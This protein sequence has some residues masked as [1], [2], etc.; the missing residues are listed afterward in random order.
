MMIPFV[1]GAYTARSPNLN[2][3]RSVCWFPVIDQED[4]K[5]IIAMYGTPGCKRFALVEAESTDTIIRAV[6]PFGAV[7]YVV[8]GDRV[9]SV[10][11][12]GTPTL[13]GTITTASGNVF[14]AD[15]GTE[16]LIVD[17]TFNGYYISGGVLTAIPDADFPTAT[18]CTFQDGY[19]IV[20]V[21]STGQIWISGLYDVTTWD[22]LDFST[23]EGSPDNALNVSSNAHDLWIFGAL[24]AEVFYNSGNADFPFERIQGAFLEVGTGAAASVCKI[25]GVFYWLTEKRQ[26]VRNVGYQFEAISTEHIEYAISQYTTI[27][28]A[29]S[30]SYTLEGHIFYVLTFPTED[31]TWVYDVKTRFWHEWQSYSNA[32]ESVPYARHRG[33]CACW[34]NGKT[35]VGDYEN[36]RLYE[37]DMATYTDNLEYIRRVRAAQTINRERYNV[38]HD[39]LEIEFE[40]GVGLSTGQGSDPQAMLDWSDDGG[41]TWSS[42]AWESLGLTV[43]GIGEYSKRARWQRLGISR[44][45]VYRVTVTDPVKCVIIAAY[46]RVRDG[47]L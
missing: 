11:S 20:T 37:L 32:Q 22:P 34:Y 7:V 19:F 8:I 28:D 30:W 24:S 5:S 14:M 21:A 1:G 16:V 23:A 25:E 12:D 29:R 17:G 26:V 3:Q 36:G 15:N 13:L 9:Y 27:S 41:H 38:V 2:A 40:M 47:Y 39:E 10:A 4:A 43:G 18:S 44:N 31:K 46:L 42:E 6:W 45:R 33:N 35:I